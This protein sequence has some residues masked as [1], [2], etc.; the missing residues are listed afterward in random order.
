MLIFTDPSDGLDYY[1]NVSLSKESNAYKIDIPDLELSI[2]VTFNQSDCSLIVKGGQ[3]L[4]DYEPYKVYTTLWDT[5]EGYLTWSNTVSMT[6]GI[7]YLEE[8]G[9]GYTIA[10]FVDDGSWGTYHPDAIRFGAFS[11]T[12]LSSSTRVDALM[13]MINPSLQRLRGTRVATYMMNNRGV[14]KANVKK[15]LR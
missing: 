6:A 7:D 5:N 9:E 15:L 4:G 1:I 14:A 2:P 3:Y 8:E 12:T 11:S 10:P 13:A